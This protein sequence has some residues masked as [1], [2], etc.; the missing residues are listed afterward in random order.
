MSVAQSP[1]NQCEK[2]AWKILKREF[3][4]KFCQGCVS[5]GLNL[6][7]KDIFAAP[8]KKHGGRREPRFPVGYPFEYLLTFASDIKNW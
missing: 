3:P 1:T 2:A 4:T 6:L 8:K 7:V 5:H